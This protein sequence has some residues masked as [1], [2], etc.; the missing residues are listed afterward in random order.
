MLRFKAY[1]NETAKRGMGA[2]T[3]NATITELFPA[4]AFNLGFKPVSVADFQKWVFQIQ[5]KL[6]SGWKNTFPVASNIDAATQL[7]DNLP[8]MD[9]KKVVEKF[10]NAIGIFKWI[11][12]IHTNRPIDKVMWGYRQKPRGV[13]PNH[14][15]DIF[16]F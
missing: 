11:Q 5:P 2:T 10:N 8:A 13:P 15:G 3:D 7:I 14:A 12:E 9:Q 4:L 16:L 1:L 6:K